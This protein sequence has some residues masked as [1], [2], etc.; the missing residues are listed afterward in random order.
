MAD[1]DLSAWLLTNRERENPHTTIDD[2]RGDGTAWSS[3]NTVRAI[4]HGRPYFA[5]LHEH[6]VGLGPGDRLYFADWRGDP[7]EQLTDDPGST[8][9]EIGRA[10]V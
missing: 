6:I 4:V 7:D 9:E 3:G 2:V 1:V 5:E 10:H 8:L